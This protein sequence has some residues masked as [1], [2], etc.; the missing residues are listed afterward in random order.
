MLVPSLHRMMSGPT[1]TL[2]QK[3]K[4]WDS[5]LFFSVSEG[6]TRNTR[7]FR[8]EAIGDRAAGAQ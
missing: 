5:I 6:R 2:D 7:P 3:A 8:F 1:A 4:K